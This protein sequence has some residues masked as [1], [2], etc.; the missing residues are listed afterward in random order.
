MSADAQPRELSRAELDA[1]AV[2]FRDEFAA[3]VDRVGAESP[4]VDEALARFEREY[5]RF[6]D[7]FH[8]F[9]AAIAEWVLAEHGHDALARLVQAGFDALVTLGGDVP[10]EAASE[11]DALA[12][13]DAMQARMRTRHDLA[14][15]Q[16][17]A[18]LGHVYRSFG[19][20]ALEA[21]LRHCGD[22]TLLGW[23]PHDL[24]RPASV[25][26][27]QWSRMMRGNFATIRVDETDDAFVI[28]QNPCGT[29]SRQIEAGCYGPPLG[30]AIVEERHPITWG[31]GH[32][33]VYRTH[34]AVMHDLMP[35]ERVGTSWPDIT[36][37]EGMGTGECR[38]V[39][40]KQPAGGG[41]VA[42]S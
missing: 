27:R 42:A 23:M 20:D 39:L 18:S 17:T 35:R 1:L 38:I 14:H 19:V 33:P 10:A 8:A 2:P 22:R 30:F 16:V 34:V 9:T 28:T 40:R 4:D 21:C 13:F 5:Q 25:R 3:T 26:V 37:P 24:A 11:S 6:V 31:R 12:R 15:A 7:G 36:C 41:P 32:I 29:C